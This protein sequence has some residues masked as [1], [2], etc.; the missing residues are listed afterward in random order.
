[1]VCGLDHS[2]SQP[3]IYHIALSA[4]AVFQV[5]AV[6]IEINNVS[7]SIAVTKTR[8]NLCYQYC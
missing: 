6:S 8:N 4:I 5:R 2:G 3:F 7:D 1:M